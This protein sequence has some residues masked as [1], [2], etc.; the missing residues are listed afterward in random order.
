VSER[1]KREIYIHINC[2]IST[3]NLYFFFNN[4]KKKKAKGDK[5]EEI[6]KFILVIPF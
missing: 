6:K 1:E 5:I 4:F 2:Q 3:K